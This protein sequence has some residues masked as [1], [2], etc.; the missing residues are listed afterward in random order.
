MGYFVPEINEPVYPVYTPHC[1]G[2]ALL[3]MRPS[4]RNNIQ[5]EY[6]AARVRDHPPVRGVRGDCVRASRAGPVVR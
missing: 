5:T 3:M 2:V 6:T 1:H 4:L